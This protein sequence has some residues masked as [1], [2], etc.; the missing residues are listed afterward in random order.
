MK[1]QN[2]QKKKT[3]KQASMV[4]CAGSGKCL[5]W[6]DKEIGEHRENKYDV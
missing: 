1:K 2:K 4:K 3:K 6:E 5:D